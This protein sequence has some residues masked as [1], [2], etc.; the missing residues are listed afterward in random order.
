VPVKF[1]IH[2]GSEADITGQRTM[3]MN[4]P[5]GSRLYADNAY[6]DYALE[7]VFA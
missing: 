3:A 5:D 7:D 6:T 4:L 2:A 1:Y